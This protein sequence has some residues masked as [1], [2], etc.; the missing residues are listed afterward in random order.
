M[1]LIHKQQDNF[2]CSFYCIANLLNLN[3]QEVEHCIAE[4]EKHPDKQMNEFYE[5]QFLRRWSNSVY[6]LTTCRISKNSKEYI[7]DP[8]LIGCVND[9]KEMDRKNIPYNVYLISIQLNEAHRILVLRGAYNNLA[10]VIDPEQADVIELKCNEIFEI[11]DIR[12]VSVL[13]DEKSGKPILM[14]YETLKHIIPI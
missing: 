14:E 3:S 10:F 4:I 2:G 6:F 8:D 13:V 12:S 5:N 7:K 11:Y 1:K 9:G